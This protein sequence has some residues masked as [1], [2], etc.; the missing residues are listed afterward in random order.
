MEAMHPPERYTATSCLSE[1]RFDDSDALSVR[2]DEGPHDWYH[3]VPGRGFVGTHAI[4]FDGSASHGVHCV[5]LHGVHR[6][7][8]HD[9][10]LIIAD[11]TELSYVIGYRLDDE[12]RYTGG[13]VAV[14][15]VLSDGTRASAYGVVDQL[16]YGL[17]PDVQGTSKAMYPHQ[18]NLRRVALGSLAGRR[19]VAVELA[20]DATPGQDVTG[21]LDRIRLGDAGDPVRSRPVDWVIA[22]R[23]TLSN[24]LF[25]RGNNLPATAWPNGFAFF[26]PV[27]DAR[28]LRWFYSW[29]D[30]NDD[31]NRPRLQA[32]AVSHQPSPWMG[33]RL[34]FQVMPQ[35]TDRPPTADPAARSIAF[36]HDHELARPHHYRVELQPDGAGP[37]VAELV[38]TDH[39]T[40]IKITFS[41]STGRF[42]L[43]NATP[44][45]R[46]DVAA[47]GTI[48]GWTH[49][50]PGPRAD[51]AGPMFVYGRFDTGAGTVAVTATGRLDDGAGPEVA[52][53]VDLASTSGP[54]TAILRLGTSYLSVDQAR[55][56]LELEQ[57]TPDAP[58]DVEDLRESAADAWD[59]RLGALE[60]DGELVDDEARTTVASHLYRLNLY[61]NS[62]HEN[63]GTADD[64]RWVHASPLL[65]AE[66][67][68]DTRTGSVVVDGKIYVNNGFWDTYRTAWP[69]YALLYP[70]LSAELVEGFLQHYREAGWIPRW[71]SPGFADCMVGTSSDVAFADA[72]VK[73]V[74]VDAET[75]YLAA[76]R[77]ATVASD[78]SRVGRKSLER[79][80][81]LGYT[82]VE[83]PEGMSWSIDGYIND[84]GIASM[85]RWLLDHDRLPDGYDRT[86]LSDELRWFTARATDYARL[87]RPDAKMF[88]GRRADG[89]W[90]VENGF[91]PDDWGDDYTET[92]A[93]NMAVSVPHDGAGLA[94][95]HG[96]RDQLGAML[97]TIFSR[98]ETGRHEGSYPR[99]MHEI[100][101]A[102]DVRMGMFG[103][104]NQPA[105]HLPF[106]WLHAGWPD[107]TQAAVREVLRR[108]HQG[109]EIGQGY[110]GDEDNGEM[111]AWHLFAALGLYPV[112]V[113]SPVY[114]VSS[115][116]YERVRVRRDD[117]VGWEV[118]APGIT[119]DTVY[120]AG[121]EVDGVAWTRPWISHRELV[122]AEE[123]RF[124]LA[125]APQPW[126]AGEAPPSVTPEV[127]GEVTAPRLLRD[128]ASTATLTGPEGLDVG[129]LI[130]D[131]SATA[132]ELAPGTA[133]EIA[134]GEA[135]DVELITL[136]SAA[137]GAAPSAW[138]LEAETTTGWT[139]IAEASA[140]TFRWP[141][142][143]RAFGVA[144]GT[145]HAAR[146][147]FTAVGPGRLAQLELLA[148][149]RSR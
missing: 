27:T 66:E 144:G 109:S 26:T 22:T 15:V 129:S 50:L 57:G 126:G 69:L 5:V 48:T 121:V 49:S 124:H 34:V 23:G 20:W 13:H 59:E 19:A 14:D 6:A 101:E 122:G 18:W 31:R 36:D 67:H 44:D 110:G 108:F 132:V 103:H 100:T 89:A 25:S 56:N 123:L 68:T 113:G 11:H 54:L 80:I 39:T 99:S 29:S 9:V 17:E 82:P 87:F 24:R 42:V 117:G 76:V 133:I 81:F 70:R 37:T 97:E 141:R 85:A 119:H 75:A 104:S 52:C 77:N 46:C 47:D 65:P 10:D 28:T 128:T 3:G 7:L 107:R 134:T 148:R 131:H 93:W 53:F 102:R 114:V 137:D 91:D 71:S 86:R 16:G 8:L 142:Q 125:D 51:G 40:A 4:R 111:S 136:T 105:H 61:P 135:V 12:L 33:D 95:L 64:P 130:D 116:L 78:D 35:S 146:F 115:P 140:D 147:R 60:I 2:I 120:V 145:V 30:H 32:L 90:R 139:L 79:A 127:D 45:G 98:P 55:R 62:G 88:H 106:Q 96:S 63:V 94:G 74:E 138:S 83:E 92:N 73:D 1:R 58:R 84:F 149:D 118:S 43:D 21:F 38:P 112:A 72:L 41:G 143:T